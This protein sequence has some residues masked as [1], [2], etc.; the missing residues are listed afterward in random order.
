[1]FD[2]F[3]VTVMAITLLLG[4][5]ALIFPGVDVTTPYAGP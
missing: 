5:A 3:L 4:L 2:K 1:M